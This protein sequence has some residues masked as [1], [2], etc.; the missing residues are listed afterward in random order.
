MAYASARGSFIIPSCRHCFMLTLH[1]ISTKEKISLA[2]S[3]MLSGWGEFWG[4]LVSKVTHRLPH[5]SHLTCKLLC[6]SALP[7][8]WMQGG[9]GAGSARTLVGVRRGEG[10]I[11]PYAL[12]LT[13]L[14]PPFTPA[15]RGCICKENVPSKVCLQCQTGPPLKCL[16]CITIEWVTHVPS[17]F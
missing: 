1:L 16:C 17:S 5:A 4:S 2:P 11:L 9:T 6:K 7:A 14:R 12:H 8:Q 15:D 10:G 3:Q 13:Y